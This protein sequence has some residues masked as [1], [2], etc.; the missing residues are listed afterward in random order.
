[1]RALL[2]SPAIFF[3]FTGPILFGFGPG[4]AFLAQSICCILSMSA[5]KVRLMSTERFLGLR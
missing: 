1:M 4:D 2:L 3:F 5:F